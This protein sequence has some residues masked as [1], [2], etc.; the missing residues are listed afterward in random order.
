MASNERGFKAEYLIP[1]YGLKRYCDQNNVCAGVEPIEALDNVGQRLIDY[2]GL[3]VGVASFGLG[4]LLT[5]G[6]EK[7][8]N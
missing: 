5:S 7:L 4:I 6:I 3:M 2:H 8:V 1:F